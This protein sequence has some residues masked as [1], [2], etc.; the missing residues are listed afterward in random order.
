MMISSG[1]DAIAIGVDDLLAVFLGESA[2]LTAGENV[3]HGFGRAAE[4]DPERRYDERPVDEDRMRHHRVDKRA[5]I[6]ADVVKTEVDIGGALLGEQLARLA[7]GQVAHM[8]TED[9]G[10]GEDGVRS[11]KIRWV[12]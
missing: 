12:E 6:E 1:L 4:P 9:G 10:V 11:C 2:K 7:G 8:R 5:V 3:E